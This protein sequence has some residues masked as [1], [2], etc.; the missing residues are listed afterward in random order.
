MKK[1]FSVAAV[2][3]IAI[4]CAGKKTQ[5]TT[6]QSADSVS[7]VVAVPEKVGGDKD[8]HGCI[9]SAGYQWSVVKNECIRTFEVAD[10]K[11]VPTKD[12]ASYTSNA[13]VVFNKDQSK[14]EL[15][16]PDQ[17]GSMILDRTGS[18]GS[19]VWK[20]DSLELFAW[21]GYV[22]RKNGNVIFHG[23]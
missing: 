17:K 14:A 19:Y 20:K 16:L 1:A 22:L 6:D 7:N 5:T 3:A 2:V 11:L 12:T 4:A 8:E 15:Y 18:E 13:V 9:G 10:I 21:K 23:E